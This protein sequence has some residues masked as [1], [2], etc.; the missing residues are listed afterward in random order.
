MKWIKPGD[1]AEREFAILGLN[2]RS[3][4]LRNIHLGAKRVNAGRGHVKFGS[5]EEL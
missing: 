2:R 5:D 4:L 3:A 1:L